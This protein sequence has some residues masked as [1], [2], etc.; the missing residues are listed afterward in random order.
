M[1]R[2]TFENYSGLCVSQVAPLQQEVERLESALQEQQQQAEQQLLTLQA[3][4]NQANKPATVRLTVPFI[5]KSNR[6]V[7]S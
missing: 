6:T 2:H 1:L 5:V 3:Q 7:L 4:A